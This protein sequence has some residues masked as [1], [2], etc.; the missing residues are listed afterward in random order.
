MRGRVSTKN[1]S[2]IFCA[3]PGDEMPQ[4]SM[5]WSL[6][7]QRPKKATQGEMINQHVYKGILRFVFFFLFLR[8]GES[9]D[10]TTCGCFTMTTHLLTMPLSIRSWPRRIS[11]LRLFFF[12]LFSRSRD[13]I[14][15]VLTLTNPCG[16]VENFRGGTSKH[17]KDTFASC[18]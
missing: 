10:C 12:F 8:K 14:L 11:V 7:S 4:L 6:T 16:V 3:R 15:R 5:D 17:V 13:V 2:L 1:E 18:G 9:C